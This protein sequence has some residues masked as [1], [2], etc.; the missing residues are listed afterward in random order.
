MIYFKFELLEKIGEFFGRIK[1]ENL[2]NR[3]GLF[4]ELG[5]NFIFISYKK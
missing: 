1:L 3:L 2:T 4:K 5:V